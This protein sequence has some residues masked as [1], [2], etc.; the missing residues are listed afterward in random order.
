[1]KL[2]VYN[3]VASITKPGGRKN[4]EDYVC[5]SQQGSYGCYLVADGL[6]G[7]RGGDLASK[8]ACESIKEAFINKPGATIERLIEYLNFA[9]RAMEALQKKINLS[10]AA[11]TT[12]VILL[13]DPRQA[14][15]AHV[16]D[17]RLY[18]FKDGCL[19]HQT[20]DHS[21]PQRLAD[22]GEIRPADIRR[23]EDRNRLLKVFDG[24]ATKN[25]SL[26]QNPTE[27][28]SGDAFL[29][30]S[31]GFWEYVFEEE[32]EQDSQLKNV[33]S[34]WLFAME[35]RLLKRATGSYDNYTA[36]ALKIR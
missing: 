15:W 35:T 34:E 4:N 3:Y 14:V 22:I 5:Y 19:A 18:F 30:C 2:K 27:I 25:F 17:S 20:K 26:H 32:M 1:L 21:I 9:G 11:K 8:V 13:T 29:L 36:L 10:N 16:G 12:L 24:H 7:H 23:H 6:G 33:P 28:N 31:D